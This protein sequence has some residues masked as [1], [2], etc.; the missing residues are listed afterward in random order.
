MEEDDLAG[1]VGF[2]VATPARTVSAG[3]NGV[4]NSLLWTRGAIH[5]DATA[6]EEAGYGA[7]SVAGPIAAAMASGMWVSS[8]LMA[9][10]QRRY[11]VRM[12]AILE[13]RVHY[14]HPVLV[15]DTVHLRATISSARRSRRRPS[16]AVLGLVGNLFNARGE[17]ALTIT[18]QILVEAPAA[19][20]TPPPAQR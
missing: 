15:G 16:H 14:L 20:D 17:S 10:L 19:S 11:G 12:L 7:L 5:T 8:G 3:E 1:V 18:E 9:G 13:S 4:L 2:S 6:A